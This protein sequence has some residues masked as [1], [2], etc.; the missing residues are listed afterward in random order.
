MGSRHNFKYNFHELVNFPALK[1]LVVMI[2]R[3]ETILEDPNQHIVYKTLNVVKKRY[4]SFN[5]PEV[6]FR[7][8]Y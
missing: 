1:I 3:Q 4:P 5:V 6:E 7:F 8:A 2:L